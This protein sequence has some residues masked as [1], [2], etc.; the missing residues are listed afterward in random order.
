MKTEQQQ[1]KRRVRAEME[2][3]C[4]ALQMH[5]GVRKWAREGTRKYCGRLQKRGWDRREL[6]ALLY[7]VLC[8]IRWDAN[9]AAKRGDK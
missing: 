6:A 8:E 2:C 4:E 7:A 1:M 5:T 9:R 3:V